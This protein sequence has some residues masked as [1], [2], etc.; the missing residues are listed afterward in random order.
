MK[1]IIGVLPFISLVLVCGEREPLLP[2][3]HEHQKVDKKEKSLH[4]MTIATVKN[5][6]QQTLNIAINN[7]VQLLVTLEQFLLLICHFLSIIM[8]KIYL[9]QK[10]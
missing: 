10:I 5:N 7:E 1:K 4:K 3:H 8:E 2:P 9:D 6:T